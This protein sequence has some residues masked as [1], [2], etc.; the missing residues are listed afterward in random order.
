M[1]VR[2]E[3]PRRPAPR[4]LA[5][6]LALVSLALARGALGAEGTPSEGGSST[7]PAPSPT[8][9]A[10]AAGAEPGARATS[11][12]P[13][14]APAAGAPP[15][16]VPAVSGSEEPPPEPALPA[17]PPARER[18]CGDRRDDDGDSL[19]DCADADCAG[20][21]SCRPTGATERSDALCSD[22]VDND[23]DGRTDCDDLDCEAAGV[24]VCLGSWPTVT[25]ATGRARSAPPDTAPRQDGLRGR[26]DADGERAD[27]TCTDGVDNDR[28]G[29]ADCEDPGCRLDPE[30]HVCS[31]SPRL[32]FSVY[33]SVAHSERLEDTRR[34]VPLARSDTNLR[35]LQLRALGPVR[36]IEGSFFVVT[37]RA[38]QTPRLTYA[39]VR[40]P[41]GRRGHYFALNSGGAGLALALTLSASKLLLLDP[42]SHV[43]AP[44]EQGNGAAAELG[45]PLDPHHRLLLRAFVAGGEGRFSTGAAGRSLADGTS[46]RTA[47]A[48][49][50]LTLRA[51]GFP[52][53]YDTQLLYAPSPPALGLS[54]GIRYDHRAQERFPAAHLGLVFRSGHLLVASEAFG[55][56]ELAFGSTQLAYDVLAGW[57]LW[58]RRLLVGAEVGVTLVGD[59]QAPPARPLED[60]GVEVAH[61]RDEA[62]ARAVA[63]VF[64]HRGVGVLSLRVVRREVRASRAAE[65]GFR[66]TELLAAASCRF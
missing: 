13:A 23:R 49:A 54:A 21:T 22:W 53:P 2:S 8:G 18:A 4:R 65:A 24:S 39:M 9:A 31:D 11:P 33:A 57:L 48:G 51:I 5:R 66:T 36:G 27:E 1:P 38:E 44:F 19:V 47:A 63:H 14:G 10:G 30:V 6:C 59:L 3:T 35:V 7:A 12:S 26:D 17:A 55:K 46:G 45:G 40:L 15:A 61:Q 56:R 41:V 25:V 34:D 32:R 50:A 52:T 62:Q 37:L 28:D 42:P 20:T 43:H 64:V 29:W 16:E 60:L 58:P